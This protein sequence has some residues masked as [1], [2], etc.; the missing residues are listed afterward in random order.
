MVSPTST[1]I[2]IQ[3][4]GAVYTILYSYQKLRRNRMLNGLPNKNLNPFHY[5]G[6]LSFVLDVLYKFQPESSHLNEHV[7][8]VHH[9]ME[10][11]DK[12]NQNPLVFSSVSV[13]WS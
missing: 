5:T 2:S 9:P 10:Q 1:D 11:V 13:E 7:T 8:H 3:D 12:L 6:M 4:M